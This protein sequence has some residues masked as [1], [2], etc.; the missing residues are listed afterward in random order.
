[1]IEYNC[2]VRVSRYGEYENTETYY[3]YL[4]EKPNEDNE[5]EVLMNEIRPEIN[6]NYDGDDDWFYGHMTW[7]LSEWEEV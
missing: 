3:V 5:V 2:Y 4:D 1:M 6:E 7:E